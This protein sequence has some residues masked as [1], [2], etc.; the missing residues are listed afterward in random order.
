MQIFIFWTYLKRACREEM[1]SHTSV[2]PMP[3]TLN[4]KKRNEDDKSL[5]ISNHH[6]W[7]RTR[8]RNQKKQAVVLFLW[9][10]EQGAGSWALSSLPIALHHHLPRHHQLITSGSRTDRV[11]LVSLR[12]FIHWAYVPANILGGSVKRGKKRWIWKYKTRALFPV[13][14]YLSAK[15]TS[16]FCL[17]S[18]CPYIFIFTGMACKPVLLSPQWLC[19]ICDSTWKTVSS[20]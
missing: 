10:S 20:V 3:I 4:A 16:A 14:T 18:L 1:L 7:S 11:R 8:F 19:H 5:V 6:G 12:M 2:K 17:I 13:S 9:E 15:Q